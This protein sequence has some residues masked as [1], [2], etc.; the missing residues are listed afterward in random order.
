MRS[1]I[2]V[3]CFG[4]SNSNFVGLFSCELSLWMEWIGIARNLHYSLIM[5]H[6]LRTQSNTY[7]EKPKRLVSLR[8]ESVCGFY[9]CVC[10]C[11]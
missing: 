5:Q 6:L 3:M 11:V 2:E 7:H 1:R 4:K 10:V 9:V 8:I